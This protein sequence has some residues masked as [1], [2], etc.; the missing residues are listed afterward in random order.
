MC[1]DRVID[2][3]R[4]VLGGKSHWVL[5]RVYGKHDVADLLCQNRATP[6]A[7]FP[8]PQGHF[9]LA[10][11]QAEVLAVW[12]QADIQAGMKPRKRYQTWREQMVQQERHSC[13]SHSS[14]EWGALANQRVRRMCEPLHSSA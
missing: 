14:V 10:P 1:R 13:Q 11:G 7:R 8:K 2:K 6:F 5:G 12:N 4:T 9:H 3:P